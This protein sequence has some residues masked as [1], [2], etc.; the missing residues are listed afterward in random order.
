MKIWS[1][2]QIKSTPLNRRQPVRLRRTNDCVSIL[3]RMTQ[4][5]I[6]KI[7]AAETKFYEP[8]QSAQRSVARGSWDGISTDCR[9]TFPERQPNRGRPQ[10]RKWAR[11]Y[12]LLHLNMEKLVVRAV[13]LF[14]ATT[15]LL[16]LFMH[17]PPSSSARPSSVRPCGIRWSGLV[18]VVLRETPSIWSSLFLQYKWFSNDTLETERNNGPRLSK[19]TVH[20]SIHPSVRPSSVRSSFRFDSTR[21]EK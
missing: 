2:R 8:L 6:N 19:Q 10:R 21:A 14:A 3:D 7:Y 9:R 18:V 1:R 13:L 16:Y 12:T 17:E 5:L 4:N 15:V 11:K 20:P